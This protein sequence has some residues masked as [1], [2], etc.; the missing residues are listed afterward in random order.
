MLYLLW[1][2]F[3]HIAMILIE[4]SL[5]INYHTNNIYYF[6]VISLFPSY[7]TNVFNFIYYLIPG[8]CDWD[9]NWTPQLWHPS[10]LP[11]FLVQIVCLLFVNMDIWF[12]C[13]RSIVSQLICRENL[14][15]RSVSMCSLLHRTDCVECRFGVWFVKLFGFKF[16][17]GFGLLDFCFWV[18]ILVSGWVNPLPNQPVQTPTLPIKPKT[19]QHSYQLLLKIAI[20]FLLAI[21]WR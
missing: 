16:G 12:A 21:Y 7:K 1:Q 3:R 8:W 15:V 10:F 17:L 9:R 13:G 2:R 19:L 14:K 4:E 11:S 6:L 5:S 18:G 20:I